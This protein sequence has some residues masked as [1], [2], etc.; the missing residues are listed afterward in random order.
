MFLTR[1]RKEES[2]DICYNMGGPW[3][4][5]DK[6]KKPITKMLYDF[7]YM[8][9]LE[10]YN[11]YRIPWLPRARVRRKRGVLQGGKVLTIRCTTMWIYL[12]YWTAHLKIKILKSMWIWS[13]LKQQSGLRITYIEFTY[14][15]LGFITF[16][17]Q[18]MKI[19]VSLHA[20]G[21]T[22]AREKH[23]S[24]L[25]AIGRHPVIEELQGSSAAVLQP[26]RAR[27][28]QQDR[29]ELSSRWGALV[30]PSLLLDLALKQFKYL[31]LE[32][33]NGL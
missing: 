27:K 9:Y 29:P 26:V 31:V 13:Q 8:R 6:W 32:R 22:G 5:Y 17:I 4:H 25:S 18:D 19:L 10:Q 12:H 30:S 16:M 33:Q 21:P 20:V 11:S 14:L 28:V 23:T 24:P 7:T 2:S 15:T 1:L 3:G